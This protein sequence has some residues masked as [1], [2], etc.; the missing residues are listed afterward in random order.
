MALA[1]NLPDLLY[2]WMAAAQPSSLWTIGTCVAVE[3]LGYGFGFT[4]Y[5]VYL[6]QCAAGPYRT[7]HYAFLTALMAIGMTVPSMLSG[8]CADRMGYTMFFWTACA[9]TLPGM[10]MA[11]WLRW[12]TTRT[13]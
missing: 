4:A 13:D 1:L 6:L 8:W 2:V 3:Q 10:A 12:R 5:T 11:V 9:L 7:A